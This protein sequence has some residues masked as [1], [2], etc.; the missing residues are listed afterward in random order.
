MLAVAMTVVAGAQGCTR[1]E[2]NFLTATV[3][4]GACGLLCTSCAPLSDR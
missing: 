4:A 1:R 3:V 2:R